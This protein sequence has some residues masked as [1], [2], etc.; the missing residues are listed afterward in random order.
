MKRSEMV[1]SQIQNKE[2]ELT[3]IAELPATEITETQAD[4]LR[5]GTKE[6]VEM[7]ELL[8]DVERLETTMDTAS[9]DGIE[10]VNVNTQTSPWEVDGKVA[11]TAD[12]SLADLRSR[13]ADG[14][15][16]Q[17]GAD[18]DAAT[19]NATR[20]A[21]STT[22]R[23]VLEA[24]LALSS[25]EYL[26]AW[27]KRLA[28]GSMALLTDSEKDA[29][30]SVQEVRRAFDTAAGADGGDW[31]P[32]GID[33]ALSYTDALITNPVRGLARKIVSST[34]VTKTITTVTPTASRDAENAEVS[35]DAPALTDKDIQAWK[36]Q[37]FI[38]ASFEL[39]TFAAVELVSII[40]GLLKDS[41]DELEATAFTTGT[42]S[43]Q[44]DGLITAIVADGT[45]TASASADTFGLAD[46]Y[47]LY[48]AVDT[49]FRSN[50]SWL[51]SIEI[52][53]EIRQFATSANHDFLTNLSGGAPAQ[54]L[55]RPVYEASGMDATYG[56]GENYVL[57]FG[58]VS[59]YTVVDVV[60]TSIVHI[61]ELMG[62]NGRPESNSGWLARKLV[63]ADLTN[64]A[65]VGVLNVT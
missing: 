45:V 3:A 7:R 38:E 10:T 34:Q 19:E 50:G 59:G 46:V 18:S 43:A 65:S 25:P 40:G 1:R 15:A 63:G 62:S 8:T 17:Q 54:L 33:G 57:A 12:L 22:D 5:T 21:Q 13:A 9:T 26:G 36:A 48:E 51:A 58:D 23:G 29:F 47:N 6:L 42:G 44:P 20:I 41:I 2:M 35:S 24:G 64:S 37:A 31:V 39:Q 14:L 61:P 30:H 49:R 52:I 53:D 16:S 60:G 28:H 32:S 4:V 55:G 27:A 56:S 11:R